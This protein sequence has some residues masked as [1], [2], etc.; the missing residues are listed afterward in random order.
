M[1]V[2]AE[3]GTKRTRYDDNDDYRSTW[4]TATVLQ[5]DDSEKTR[6]EIIILL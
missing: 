2:R 4:P 6:R 1:A 3:S 5:N